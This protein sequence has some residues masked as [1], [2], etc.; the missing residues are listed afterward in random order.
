M[1][2][3]LSVRKWLNFGNT[4]PEE[5]ELDDI[6]ARILR[7]Q[8]EAQTFTSTI[9][10]S[11]IVELFIKKTSASITKEVSYEGFIKEVYK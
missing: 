3:D 6:A 4:N 8:D 7:N 10:F 5:K 11:E 9:S 2:K 1:L